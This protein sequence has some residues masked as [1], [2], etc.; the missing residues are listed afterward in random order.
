[1]DNTVLIGNGDMLQETAIARVGYGK[2]VIDAMS[3]MNFDMM[4]VG[5]HEFDWG[6]NQFLS[7]FDGD[8]SNGEASFPLVNSNIYYENQ[9]VTK[10]NQVTSSLLLEK[11]DVKVGILSYIGNVYSSI[12]ANMTE[13]Y[14]FK[15]RP[16]EIAESVETLGKTLKDQGADILIVN[17][18]DGESSSCKDYEANELLAN[19]KYN[20]SYLVDAV[21]NGH[22]HTKQDALFQRKNGIALPVI[23]SSG[24]L[25]DFGRIDL[26]Y[27]VTKKKVTSAKATH[28]NVSKAD[29]ID[30]EVQK[31]IDNHYTASKDILEEVY[32]KNLQY[33]QRYDQNFQAY[34]S[35]VMMAATGATASICNT[36]AFRNNVPTGNFDFNVL[37][38]LNP[39]DNH[40]ILCEI[41]GIDLKRF[42][43]ANREKE[44]VYTKEYGASIA[45]D[46]TYTLAIIDY[47]YFGSY[48]AGYRTATYTDT[49]LVLRDLIAQ[50]LRLRKDT[51]FTVDKDYSNI[52]LS[53]VI[54]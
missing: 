5:N 6:F 7:Y 41:S 32:C 54:N 28:I 52:L 19:L 33:I 13:G 44:I 1:E 46:Q 53:R 51:G 2:V 24:K 50:D 18:H 23:Q 17:I 29:G 3:Q 45:T 21:I 12:N 37:Y 14:T 31:I 27:D 43:D 35:N 42:Y 8:T 30:E 25:T 10:G 49:N 9:L 15:G 22:T 26:T 34:I 40:I 39:F 48:F 38:A 16:K 11:D 36:G 47:V 4:G 20:D